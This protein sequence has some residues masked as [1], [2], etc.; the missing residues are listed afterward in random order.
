MQAEELNT[1]VLKALE[2][3]KGL[4][5]VTLD[6]MDKTSITDQMIICTG[7]S[8]RHVKSLADK[9]IEQAKQN[10]YPPLGIEGD[11]QAEWILVDLG[12]VIIHVMQ[13]ATREF[14]NLEKLWSVTNNEVDRQGVE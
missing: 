10:G 13:S 3:L 8:K 14:Y 2:E 1:I 4:E 7:T 9:V 5:I 12:D 6:V 11:D